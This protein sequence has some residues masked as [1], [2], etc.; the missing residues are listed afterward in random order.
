MQRPPHPLRGRGHFNLLRI[1]CVGDR[2]DERGGSADAAE[3][4]HPLRADGVV[5]LVGTSAPCSSM[6]GKWSAR[7]SA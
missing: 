6:S 5:F 7:G 1:G 3:L 2:V 4:S